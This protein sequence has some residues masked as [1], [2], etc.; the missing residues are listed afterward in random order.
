[1]T[2]PRK[3]KDCPPDSKR[4]APYPGPR[5]HTHDRAESKRRKEAQ[6]EARVQRTYG[7]GP[8]D[9]DRLY[10]IQDGRCFMCRRA[11]G[12]SRKLSVDHDHKTNDVRGLL[13]RTCNNI[14]GFARDDIQFFVRAISYL[15]NPPALLLKD[16]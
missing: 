15:S 9:Y 5:C 13:C 4:P 7:L 6:H 1:M 10:Q 8:G 16:P 3:C 12:A 2:K 14:L 11:T